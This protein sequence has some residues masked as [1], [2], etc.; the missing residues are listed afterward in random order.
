MVVT[1]P[2]DEFRNCGVLL[3]GVSCM[4]AIVFHR[5][6]PAFDRQGSAPKLTDVLLALAQGR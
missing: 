6:P 4:L 5:H 1:A 2:V 3:F